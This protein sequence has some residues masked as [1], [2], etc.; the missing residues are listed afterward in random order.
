MYYSKF[1][2]TEPNF[3][4]YFA[5][6]QP[7]VIHSRGV[8]QTEKKLFLEND[9]RKTAQRSKRSLVMFLCAGKYLVHRFNNDN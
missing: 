6:R 8:Q 4:R 3:Q 1:S 5:L 7:K 2:K 9:S